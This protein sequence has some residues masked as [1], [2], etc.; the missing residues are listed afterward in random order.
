MKSK[1]VDE[2]WEKFYKETQ[3]EDLPWFTKKLDYDLE[4][5]IKPS[6]GLSQNY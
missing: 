5:E 4:N 3:I 2:D 1:K 6:P